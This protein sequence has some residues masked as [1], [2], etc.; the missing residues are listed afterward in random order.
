MYNFEQLIKM[1]ELESKERKKSEEVY[2]YII[3]DKL[4]EYIKNEKSK[5]PDA[6]VGNNV[7]NIILKYLAEISKFKLKSKLIEYYL[8]NNIHSDENGIRSVYNKIINK[9]KNGEI[10]IKNIK[11]EDLKYS[12]NIQK[13]MEDFVI[14]LI[15]DIREEKSSVMESIEG[16]ENI[17]TVLKSKTSKEREKIICRFIPDE[18]ER[19]A[20]KRNF[21]NFMK[22]ESELVEDFGKKLIEESGK[23]VKKECI[24]SIM[25]STQ[26]LDEL[27]L[28]EYYTNA[29]NK[30]YQKISV[31]LCYDY[32]Q[33]KKLLSEENLKKLNVEQLILMSSFWNNRVNKIMKDLAKVYYFINNK[34]LLTE[35]NVDGKDVFCFMPEQVQKV[36][37]KMN[38]LH[39][40]SFELL[41]NIQNKNLNSKKTCI[42]DNINETCEN[43]SRIELEP[44]VNKICGIYSKQYKKYFDKLFPKSENSLEKD[45]YNTIIFENIRYNSYAAKGDCMIGALMCLF[46]DKSGTTKN[47]GYV[48]E[49]NSKGKKEILINADIQGFNTCFSLHINKDLV[50]NFLNEK[51]GNTNM[52]KYKGAEDFKIGENEILK[53]QI[54]VPL[55]KEAEN[56]IKKATERLTPLDRYAKLIRHL[57]GL[58]EGEKMANHLMEPYNSGK[59]GQK[60]KYVQEYIDLSKRNLN[61]KKNNEER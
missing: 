40:V 1:S 10:K 18:K 54:Y 35:K 3:A 14:L 61:M 13:S 8:R 58:I 43:K 27:G 44:Y 5:N 25:L 24:D 34:E 53:A 9:E 4:I 42:E 11:K 15:K 57:N 26:L 30:S 36:G 55:T 23:E 47:F 7:Y 31:N 51:Q 12:F 46:N 50:I 41:R 2:F 39:K 6:S 37:I 32:E 19:K 20:F 56:S 59:K 49:P 48:E 52:P 22:S 38:F 60:Y 17:I 28:L 45:L 21:V 16:F 29:N 33:V